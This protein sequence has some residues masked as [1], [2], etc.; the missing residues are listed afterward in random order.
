MANQYYKSWDAKSS[1]MISFFDKF[2]VKNQTDRE[3]LNCDLDLLQSIVEYFSA[4]ENQKIF[5]NLYI[6][7]M[8]NKSWI[9]QEYCDKV[10]IPQYFFKGFFHL[11]GEECLQGLRL[12]NPKDPS[13][14]YSYEIPQVRTYSITKAFSMGE[15]PCPN[16]FARELE[17]LFDIEITEE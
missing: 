12:G 5:T 16:C 11:W 3:I 2:P 8:K 6:E 7:K 1:Q 15:I 14:K 10:S 13:Y 17:E 4:E 9:S